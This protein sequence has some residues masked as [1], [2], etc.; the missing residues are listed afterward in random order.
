MGL[1]PSETLIIEDSHA[2]RIAALESGANL[3]RIKELK[4]LNQ[5]RINFFLKT[6]NGNNN[7]NT[8]PW[9]DEELNIVI[10]MAGMGKDFKMLDIFFQTINRNK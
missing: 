3:L 4:S 7:L 2:G 9:I 10:P 1:K 6:L 8:R 5:K